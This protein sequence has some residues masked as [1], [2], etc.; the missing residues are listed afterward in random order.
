MLRRLSGNLTLVLVAVLLV[1]IPVALVVVSHTHWARDRV[2][3]LLAAGMADYF[4]RE[5][6]VGPVTLALPHSVTIDGLA[7]AEGQ[8]LQD[9][10][11]ITAERLR[12]EL[13]LWSVICG[14]LAP[15][16]SV[17]NVNVWGLRVR[18]V[19]DPRGHLNLADIIPK[20]RLLTPEKRFR[21]R[22]WLHD[23]ALV[24]EDH[25]PHVR[26]TPPA[27]LRVGD[28]QAQADFAQVLSVTGSV[29][30]RLLDGRGGPFAAQFMADLNGPFF[31][32]DL[33]LSDLDA[34]WFFARYAPPGAVSITGGRVEVAGSLYQIAY[35]GKKQQDF[36]LGVRLN[37]L[38]VGV[39]Q[40]GA[41]PAVLTGTVWAS[42]D[43]V[44][45]RQLQAQFAGSTYELTGAVHDFKH[46]LLDIALTSN[47][48]RLGPLLQAVPARARKDLTIPA[49]GYAAVVAQVI[50]PADNPDLRLHVNM[51]E[52]LTVKVAELGT[53]RAEG[54]EATADVIGLREPS[55]RATVGARRV[56]IPSIKIDVKQAGAL[57]RE[58]VVGPMQ[59]LRARVAFC[60]GQPLAQATIAAPYVRVGDLKVG[61][62]ST[63][64]TLA[65]DQLRLQGFKAQ[66]L[67]GLLTGE[68][69]LSLKHPALGVRTRGSERGVDLARLRE[70][71][72]KVP[73]GLAGT[74]NA[75]FQAQITGKRFVGRASFDA[76]H[77]ATAKATVGTVS[78]TVGVEDNGQLS[79]AGRVSASKVVAGGLKLDRLEA[80]VTLKGHKLNIASGHAVGPD[81]I[82][83]AR[84][85]YDL[86][87]EQ[88]DLD[89]WAAELAMAPVTTYIG[90]ENVA[91]TGYLKGHVT[92]S[93]KTVHFDGHLTM[94]DAD[95]YSYSLTALV[96][97]LT[98]EPG[99]LGLNNLLVSRGS[100]AIGGHIVLGNLAA[101]APQTTIE[102]HLASER[103][104]LREVAQIFKRD[105]PVAGYGDLTVDLSG[106]LASARAS[107]VLN[108]TNAEYK[109]FVLAQAR[110]PFEL[111][112]DKLTV[113]EG[114]ALLL[115]APTRFHG[116]VLLTETPV[117]DA[118]LSA[119]AL[120]L[121]GLAPLLNAN[122]PIAGSAEIPNLWVRGP[123]NDL[124]G[125]GRIVAQDVMIGDE[126]LHDVDA[127]FS[128]SRGQLQL[129]ETTFQAAGGRLVVTGA[130]NMA[131]KPRTLVAHVNLVQTGLSD[132]LHLALP[133]AAAVDQRAQAD[134]DELRLM[135][136]RYA[137]RLDGTLGGN[138]NLEGP[139]NA[140]TAV[141]DLH[142]DDAVLDGN[143]LPHVDL[144]ARV[145]KDRLDDVTLNLRQGDA[146]V[147]ATGNMA[148]DGPIAMTVYG[149]A[150]NMAQLSPWL[151]LDVPCG[152]KLGFTVDATGSSKQPDLTASIDVE[153]PSFAGVQFDVLN[154]PI[155]TVREGQ[156]DVDTLIIKRQERQ[157]VIDGQLPF[158]WHLEREQDGVVTRRPGLVPDG[159]I[160]M[161]GRIENTPV[162][163]FLPLMDEY[164]RAKRAAS[165][166][167]SD[168]GFRWASIKAEGQLQST[169]SVLG[170]VRQP[171]LRG[172]L[173]LEN[174]AVQPAG[175][176]TP[177][178]DLRMDVQF[179]G[180]G[181]DNLVEVRDLAARYQELQANLTGQF[182]L[183][184]S[185]PPP[186]EP[187]RPARRPQPGFWDNNFD[188]KL[189][190]KAPQYKLPM[191]TE[192]T[193]LDG[194]FT[195]RTENKAQVL[196]AD[197]LT[198]KVGG[199]EAKLSGESV[200]TSFRLAD[201]ARNQWDYHLTLNRGRI[202]VNPFLTARLSGALDLVTPPGARQAVLQGKW[203]VD[204]GL[205]GVVAPPSGPVPF[206]ALSSRFPSP[207]LDLTVATGTNFRLH[208]SGVDAPIEPNPAAAQISGTLQ[209]PSI[210]GSIT[211]RHGTTALPTSTVRLNELTVAYA[212]E[213]LPGDR[214][215]PVQL[216]LHG[217]INGSAQGTIARPGASSIRINVRISGD[218]PDRIRIT[219]TS[220]PP[221]S[222]SQ[223]Y[224]LLGGVPFA[225][226]PGVGTGEVNVGQV[227]SEQF[228]ATLATAFRV[229]VFQ[230]IEEQLKRALGLSELGITFNFNQPV[231]LQ[232]GK[233]LV[234]NLLVTYEQPL[235]EGSSRYDVRVSYEL[236]GGLRISYHN[237]ERNINQLEIGYSFTY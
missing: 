168:T 229:R 205:V 157:I 139:T 219:T 30:G 204:E 184:P 70:L 67:G 167:G 19:V 179:T 208:G 194:A 162:A 230:P 182:S 180:T 169:V 235:L 123:T 149:S 65:G 107:G 163:F 6:A 12:L 189:A 80:L 42:R 131:A 170:T 83:W 236:P 222:E 22:V 76:A 48:A 53:V 227:L 3:G 44:E 152:G 43:A 37:G 55:V 105:V 202:V 38:G 82:L 207:T 121:E 142:A 21:G 122:L 188:L 14:R 32:L 228:L 49:G 91:G 234:Q 112:G 63:E 7:I 176:K 36:A 66:A 117:V 209:R 35:Q 213:P 95:V 120:R 174:G 73:T 221:L 15:A 109:G 11:A 45:I 127:N 186:T 135:L 58:V 220:D 178:S 192:I 215:D 93:D 125:G 39:A 203:T 51:Q 31:N 116:T 57:G 223:I 4:Q 16:A 193:G 161:G 183:N 98:Y 151:P 74:A 69:S 200:L 218:L 8:R 59:G 113:P 159:K 87:Q 134:R 136:R 108:L 71:P 61:S 94:F 41:G 172:S 128:L 25:S 155:A 118:T 27:L 104:S 92:Q 156:I 150:I 114:E 64:A 88:L 96:A 153:N 126:N 141:V 165:L 226:L 111:V 147:T 196:R 50:G 119:G 103:V 195:F 129:S 52:G 233:Y 175:W 232:V 214:N 115:D 173:Q 5:V 77:F 224:A 201:L 2:H 84:G 171:T 132:L 97:D 212:L 181:R 130:Y 101:P 56:Q 68:A 166:Q 54:L 28:L 46:P 60:G 164:L 231:T 197:G 13:D 148:F 146:L 216:W 138:I 100:T 81:G 1:A 185:Q 158:S 90:L 23:A 210:T 102:G 17:G 89:V 34:A 237:D 140:P 86:K 199:G 187:N 160:T 144:A 137:L 10:A 225:A 85:D 177:L 33:S 99:T 26:R 133:I 154:V 191:G 211:S 198:F 29:R 190:L 47:A 20:P 24:F 9:G 40:V 143:A 62:L 124:Q 110:V 79:G 217:Q 106:S 78:G 206:H 75:D 18:A 145:S 72:L